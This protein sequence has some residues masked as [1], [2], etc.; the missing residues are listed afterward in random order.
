MVIQNLLVELQTEE[1]PPKALH[2]LMEAFAQGIH[3]SLAEAGFLT[4]N[5]V[6]TPYASPRRLAVHV[7]AV[8]AKSPDVPVT[9]R[10]VPV[11]VG[12]DAQGNATP[13]LEKKMAALGIQCAV[14]DLKRVM[15]GKNEQLVYEGVNP[16]VAIAQGVQTALEDAVKN[17]P[18]PKVMTYQLADGETT[19]AFVRPVKH[20]IALFGAD[21]LPVK[22]FGLDADRITMGHRFHTTDPVAVANADAYE[23]SLLAAKVMPRFEAR[24]ELLRQELTRRAEALEATVIMP[25]DLLEEATALTEWPVV[26][27]STF[28][29]AFLEVP[30][31]CLILTM[32]LNQKY[33]ALRGRNGKLM[34]RFLLVSQLEAKDGGAAISAGNARVVRARLA[35]AKFFYDQ[36]R[37]STLASRVEGLKH[38]VYHNKLGSQAERVVRVKAM[39]RHFAQR[40]GANADWAERAALLAKADLRTLMVGEFP[41]LQGIMGEYYA[42][43]DKE[44]DEV[45][46]AIR[47]HY[48]PRY[49]GDALPSTNVSLAVA[50]A[51]K[52]ETLIGMFGIGQMP[53]GEKDP[54]A[55]RRHA[56][57]V[58]RMLIEKDLDVA[59]SDLI[60]DAWNVEKDVAGIAD[61]RDALTQFFA[62]RLRVMLR[63]MGYSALEVDAVLA[64]NPSKLN[65]LTKRLAAVRA[66]MAL[67]E[68]T[69]LTAANKRIVNIL[70]KAE[71]EAIPEA[72]DPARFVEPAEVA[73]WDKLQA[74]APEA[75]AHFASGNFEA[76]LTTLAVLKDAVDSFF[77]SVMV[78]AEDPALRMNR[79]ALLKS[80]YEVMN[81][82]AEISRLA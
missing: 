60:N 54:F 73:L 82:V 21:V 78:N 61:N 27:E 5:S 4:D 33:F 65:D 42:H 17:L 14:S 76:M 62:D 72:V 50:L 2:K 25:E 31:E 66:F 24:L 40:L 51:D 16:G 12:L 38:V 34:N 75:Q 71:G 26:Y 53:T 57:G 23:A 41:E 32:Q 68:A 77:E 22:L 28:E 18:I 1:L 47:E 6:V 56:L 49:A 58:L 20:L 36:D 30:E 10:L 39:A 44:P 11:R 35:D 15:D 70:K 79:H 80:L 7:S 81:K 8:L 19:V 46:L 74:V 29:E 63:D 3:K 67:P 9:T 48:Q 45:A 43:H 52:M 55:L 13:A 59:L 64:L 69:S 37:Q